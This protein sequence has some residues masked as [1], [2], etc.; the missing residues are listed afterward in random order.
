MSKECWIVIILHAVTEIHKRLQED[1]ISI[2]CQPLMYAGGG[3]VT[4]HFLPELQYPG[5]YRYIYYKTSI[6]Y[7]KSIK[8][9]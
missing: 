2:G 5:R 6:L 7:M 8:Q 3:M 9:D 4:V 1:N